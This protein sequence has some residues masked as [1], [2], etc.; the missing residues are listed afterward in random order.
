MTPLQTEAHQRHKRF[1]QAIAERAAKIAKKPETQI[2]QEA[3]SSFNDWV[4]RQERLNPLPKE[5]WF[6]I[7]GES[8]PPTPTVGAIQRAICQHFNVSKRDLLSARRTVDICRPRQIGYYLT[9]KLTGR[10]LPEIGRRFGGRDHTSAL[11]G[12]RKIEQLR[13]CDAVLE[14]DLHAIAA[15][16]GGSLS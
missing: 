14:S 10:S 11:S 3:P 2:V 12:I 7:V 6:S 13:T 1:H 4:A 16:V 9:K 5:T 8:D 15:S